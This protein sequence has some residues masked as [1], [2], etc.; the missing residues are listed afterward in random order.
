MMV[1]KYKEE[2]FL[3]CTPFSRFQRGEHKQLLPRAELR[4]RVKAAASGERAV[5]IC[6][7]WRYL[8]SVE[9]R[10]S[11]LWALI[12]MWGED[13]PGVCSEFRFKLSQN[14]ATLAPPRAIFA[15]YLWRVLLNPQKSPVPAL[16][17]RCS[18]WVR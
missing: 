17:L 8:L 7:G 1:L 4:F 14:K 10:N 12:E 11:H 2:C 6:G 15:N 18:S 13:E 16:F 5:R 3:L 9:L